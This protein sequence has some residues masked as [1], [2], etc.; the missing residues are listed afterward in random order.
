MSKREESTPS[1][2]TG[3][4]HIFVAEQ[5]RRGKSRSQPNRD[6]NPYNRETLLEI[7]QASAE[8]L[9]EA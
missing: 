5:W 3:L 6:V 2:Y 9:N 1:V 8:D 4:D 7:P